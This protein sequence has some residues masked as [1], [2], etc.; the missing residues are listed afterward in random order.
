[1]LNLEKVESQEP[2]NL[3]VDLKP[4][5]KPNRPFFVMNEVD[6]LWCSRPVLHVML[7]I[8]FDLQ[9]ESINALHRIKCHDILGELYSF[10]CE[11]S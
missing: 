3:P 9:K 6:I 10:I 4:P 8:P 5:P 2:L 7:P 11:G 1:M